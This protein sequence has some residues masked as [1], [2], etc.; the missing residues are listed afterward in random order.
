MKDKKTG[1]TDQ[2]FSNDTA[3]ETGNMDARKESSLDDYA[4][5]EGG[6]SSPQYAK[7]EQ[8]NNN[9]DFQK[10]DKLLQDNESGLENGFEGGMH[11][12]A[13]AQNDIAPS[14]T[15]TSSIEATTGE[16]AFSD[17]IQ[18]ITV[19]VG[20]SIAEAGL[21]ASGVGAAPAAF[22]EVTKRFFQGKK[23][24]D[25]ADNQINSALETGEGEEEH[26]SVFL[27]ILFIVVAVIWFLFMAWSTEITSGNFSTMSQVD[28]FNEEHHS[29]GFSF[30][31]KFLK[32]ENVFDRTKNNQYGEEYV[33]FFK[34]L[35]YNRI[36]TK[37]KNDV[38]YEHMEE[39]LDTQ[40]GYYKANGQLDIPKSLASYDNF[41]EIFENIN[42]AE[43]IAVFSQDPEWDHKNYDKTKFYK[44]FNEVSIMRKFYHLNTEL[45][46][47][48]EPV[49]DAQGIQ[50]GTRKKY[51]VNFIATRYGI[52][53]LYDMCP[54][55]IQYYTS[56]HIYDGLQNYS[57]EDFAIRDSHQ[58][59]SLLP[60]Q[61]LFIRS[62]SDKVDFGSEERSSLFG[63]SP[64]YKDADNPFESLNS[65]FFPTLNKD[66]YTAVPTNSPMVAYALSLLGNPYVWGGN[67]LTNGADCSH[68]VNLI[69]N[70]FG[71]NY[72][73]A[74]ADRIQSVSK[75]SKVKTSQAKPG[76]LVH[77][78]G[79]IAMVVA[80]NNDGTVRTVEA[81]S[82]K[83][84][85]V[86]RVTSVQKWD[87]A[88]HYNGAPEYSTH[89]NTK[90]IMPD[91]SRYI[92]NYSKNYQMTKNTTPSGATINI[93]Q[94]GQ[95][96]TGRD[97]NSN[98]THTATRSASD[99]YTIEMSCGYA[100]RSGKYNTIVNR[101]DNVKAMTNG[102]NEGKQGELLTVNVAGE[103]YYVCALASGFMDVYGTY[104]ITL[105]N[106]T[107]FK[108]VTVDAKSNN[109]A[110]G[111]GAT[112]QANTQYG[113]GYFDAGHGT[114]QMNVVEFFDAGDSRYGN[115]ATVYSNQPNIA[116]D[117]YVT[118]ITPLSNLS[119][120]K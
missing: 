77:Y 115:S 63:Y 1:F 91:G 65:T 31:L 6:F 61:E 36:Y 30:M 14:N 100:R 82:S 17:G 45:I 92:P 105:S 66:Y 16:N 48:Y 62:M 107:A 56:H 15:N 79:H 73:Y 90:S 27:R 93:P 18:D 60:I 120:L 96:I 44:H 28:T 72:S 97:I 7:K 51:Y 118:S 113:H 40:Y 95:A 29:K 84:G 99:S 87:Y 38:I 68:F 111:S 43:M 22:L 25:S 98:T 114:I 46:P 5:D 55:G 54:S 19:E 78:G 74:Q 81:W 103:P 42:Y 12:N 83:T 10:Q 75:F 88:L 106:G 86:T 47:F 39:I 41:G 59:K 35:L 112:L 109:D 116:G 101:I 69:Y 58:Y 53:D 8:I 57:E 102:S 119:E 108:C 26:P 117:T 23:V 9:Q 34:D 3:F 94:P 104:E 33:N 64:G 110:V 52:Y 2:N 85:V 67:S 37:N 80:V 70:K 76:D 13:G 11:Q 71:L 49:Y 21:A 20:S 89:I 32:L 4:L 24:V 50:R